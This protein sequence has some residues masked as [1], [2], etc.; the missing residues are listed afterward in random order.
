MSRLDSADIALV[1]SLAG[2]LTARR[3]HRQYKG[4]HRAL[5]ATATC[6]GS[7]ERAHAP[8]SSGQL[9]AGLYMVDKL[10]CDLPKVDGCRLSWLNSERIVFHVVFRHVDPGLP[11]DDMTLER[12]L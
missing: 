3:K 2:P 1:Y 11:V 7:L 9:H 10:R 4:G 5:S 12:D 6:S 8:P